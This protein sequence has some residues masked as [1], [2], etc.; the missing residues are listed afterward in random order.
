MIWKALF[1]L[2]V[3][4]LLGFALYGFYMAIWGVMDE[5]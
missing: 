1:G 4:I 3:L 2:S 5:Y